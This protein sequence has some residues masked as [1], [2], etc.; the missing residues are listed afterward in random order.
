MN[1][2]DRIRVLFRTIIKLGIIN[3]AYVAWYRFTL[4][5]GLR[6]F[7]F[8]QRTIQF[9][10]D[11]YEPSKTRI[12]FPLPWKS[13]LILDADRI[14]EGQLRYFGY[15]WKTIGNPPHWYLN[16]FGRTT[17]PDTDLHWTVLSDFHPRVG[18]IKNIWEASRFEWIVTLARAHAVT[19][20][21]NYL[22]VLNSYLHDWAAKNP[23]NTGPNWKC[24]QEASIRLFNLIN[25]SMILSQSEKP[26]KA[27]SDLIYLHL[28]RISL[29]ILYGIVQNNNHGTSEATALF[30][31]GN[32]LLRLGTGYSKAKH[33]ANKG[34][35][36]LENRIKKL[37]GEDGSFSQHSTT[38]HRVL[39][40]TLIYAEY[41]RRNLEL[42]AFSPAFYAKARLAI[43]WLG[44]LTDE[45]SGDCPNLG[46]ND[47]AM[48]LNMHSCNYREFRPSLQ[49]ANVIFNGMK[50][51]TNGP[52][53]EP[54]Y[55]FNLKTDSIQLESRQ[56]NTKLL[57]GGYV[58][59]KSLNSWCLLRFPNF[60]F[61]PSQNDVFHFDLWHHGKNILC[62]SGTFSYNASL[63]ETKF[64]FGSVHAHNTIS[65][66]GY[67]QMPR[68]G[69]FLRGNWIKPDKI[70]N[71]NT[72]HDGKQSWEGQ[73]TDSRG[74][75]H[76]RRIDNLE[77]NWII[78]DIVSGNFG[79][80]K[81]G[82]NLLPQHLTVDDNTVH[83][84]WG[85]IEIPK[86]SKFM[87]QDGYASD[88]YW[89]SHPILRLIIHLDKPG[90]YITTISLKS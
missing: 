71:I 49:T 74:N 34:R 8:P 13:Q 11:F 61:R 53:D 85:S 78:T 70:G 47:G 60:R 30:V 84:S 26:L 77:N 67:E 89:E 56:Y 75:S 52:W 76:M 4:K 18:D 22:N 20:K 55:W 69:R 31:G 21:M 38:Y 33:F 79:S 83:A 14:I 25:A 40:D 44:T 59:I 19:G 32:W 90:K 81:G 28:Q 82:F 39:I 58:V 36:W 37:I 3:V 51:F 6:K 23:L 50:C 73:Y 17:Y 80:A 15:H 10:G 24:G 41:W 27:L 63:V 88:Y 48:F 29:N 62:D 87:V 72:E 45:L 2:L 64:T 9:S 42:P 5:S 65:F 57:S 86:Q 7:L 1:K 46:S 16:P 68:L 12:D 66:D 35:F 43:S 54:L